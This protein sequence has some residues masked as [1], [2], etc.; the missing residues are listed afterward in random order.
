VKEFLSELSDGVFGRL[1]T[2]DL[3]VPGD[4]LHAALYLLVHRVS[5]L[6]ELVDPQ[7]H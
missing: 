6:T 2:D 1:V 7:L 3:V 4:D 5:L